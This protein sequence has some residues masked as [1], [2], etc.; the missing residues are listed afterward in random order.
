MLSQLFNRL[1]ELF[2]ELVEFRRDLHMYP[3]LSFHEVNTPKKVAKFLTDL[4]IEV[5]TGVGG[6]GVVGTL[7]GGKPGKTVA[8]RADFDALPIQD[9]KEV[10]YKSK[11]PGVMHA[12]GHDIHTAT[13]LGVAKVLSEVK[14]DLEGNVVFIHQFAEELA[15][16]G[17]K[18]MIEDGCLEGVDVIY[19]SHVW[20]MDPYGTVGVTEGFTMAASDSFEIEIVG[21]GGH[22][23]TPHLTVDPL[24]VAS[25]LVLNLQQIVSRRVDPLK[26]AVVTVGSFHSGEAFNVIPNTAK[27]KGTVRTFD[28]E[29]RD[30]IEEAIGQ[31][32]TATCDNAGATANYKYARGYPALWNHPEEIRRVEELAQGVIGPEKVN[33]MEPI[34]GGE[35]FAYYLQEVP[36]AFFFVGGGNPDIGATYPHHH[37]M[38][39][40]D[41]RSMMIT[42]KLFIS[43]VLNYLS[44]GS[45]KPGL[46]INEQNVG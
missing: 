35:D 23:A 36:G 40:V 42:G 6:R 38:F 3:E 45:L 46:A 15:P 2:P 32:T 29:V 20:A 16:G 25:Q 10:P 27:L 28:E 5:R 7:K 12:C 39:N 17:A 33:R 44:E 8:L 41:E 21:R 31:I 9:E 43:S 11:V 14:K 34:M 22:G 1:E 24:V 30:M 18:P 4:G 19:G 26:P 37:P 13:L